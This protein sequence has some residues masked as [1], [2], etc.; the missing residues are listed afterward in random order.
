MLVSTRTEYSK[1][2]IILHW[3]VA[4]LIL[5]AWLTGDNMGRVLRAR[6]DSGTTGFE[7]STPHVW[8]GCAVF[9]LILVRLVL[10]RIQGA[11][12]A[13]PG[14]TEMMEKAALWGHRV[15]YLLMIAVPALGA[16]AWFGG[17]R[18]A[19]EAHET[20]SNAL[21]L[22]ALGHAVVAI[23]HHVIRKDGALDRMRL[24]QKG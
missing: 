10:R 8:L 24:S 23:W 7:G 19:G 18:A 12:G 16:L 2:Q 22:V 9:V 14:S 13:L 1:A 15:I 11:P 5:V 6:F 17:V 3:L 21:L 20:A 4:I